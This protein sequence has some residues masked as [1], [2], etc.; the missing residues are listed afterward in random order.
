MSSIAR[1]GNS[2]MQSRI[3]CPVSLKS[4]R[5]PA[6]EADRNFA[7]RIVSAGRDVSKRRLDNGA[8][9]GVVVGDG[10]GLATHA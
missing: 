8:D 5:I 4:L 3:S 7:Y 2:E 9:L 6:V 10:V 1:A